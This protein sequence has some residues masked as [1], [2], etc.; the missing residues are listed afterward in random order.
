MILSLKPDRTFDL[1]WL[2]R[3]YTG[4][5]EILNKKQ[6]ILKFDEITDISILLGSGV[7]LDKEREVKFIHKNKIK[8]NHFILKREK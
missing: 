2:K 7:I 3:N 8:I 6:L 4:K 5:W 1:H